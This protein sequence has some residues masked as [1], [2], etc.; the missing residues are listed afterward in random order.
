MGD[1]KQISDW[2]QISVEVDPVQADGLEAL[3][4]EILP[5]SLVVERNYGDLFPHELAG[6]QGP[7]IIRGYFP[8]EVSPDITPRI[9]AALRQAGFSQQVEISPLKKENWAT[10]WQARYQP[11]PV[12]QRLVVVPSWLDNP[13]PERLV[14]Y[15]DPGMAFG[16]G[17][18]PT[19]QLSLEMLER[20]AVQFK[21]A[22]MID[23]GCGSGILSIAGAKL[24]FKQVLGVD[25]DPD[26][27][28]VSCRNADANQ[29][30]QTT[31]FQ[32]GSVEELLQLSEAI[33]PSP[34][35]AANIIAPILSDLFQ[36]GLGELVSPR[37][38]LVLSGI[39]E[40]QAGGILEWLEKS[41]FELW[42]RRQKEEWVGLIGLKQDRGKSSPA[43]SQV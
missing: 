2:I 8:A 31:H 38:C 20:C 36:A 5:G 15:M 40:E 17:T 27:V 13:Y 33:Q 28:D 21:P 41:G 23:V 26:A 1:P 22:R 11:I 3:L 25:I 29:V 12:G 34:L 43:Q 7:V 9:Q 24:G 39:L 14:I 32:P 19:T 4:G 10:A 35:V 18:H 37:G 16:S 30:G 6:Y 42:E